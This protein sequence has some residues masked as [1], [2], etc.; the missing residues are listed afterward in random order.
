MSG[1]T[2]KKY[3]LPNMNFEATAIRFED[4]VVGLCYHGT[5]IWQEGDPRWDETIQ[6]DWQTIWKYGHPCAFADLPADM[7]LTCPKCGEKISAGDR[8]CRHCGIIFSK[9]LPP[10]GTDPAA[11]AVLAEEQAVRKR[12]S[13]ILD[14]ILLVVALLI[15]AGLGYYFFRP[16]SSEAPSHSVPPSTRHALPPAKSAPAD[17]PAA[18]AS[19]PQQTGSTSGRE[20]SVSPDNPPARQP[21]PPAGGFYSHINLENQAEA[22]AALQ[23]E[24]KQIENERRRLEEAQARAETPAAKE[25]LEKEAT[26][27]NARLTELRKIVDAYNE[28]Y[29]K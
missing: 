25:A 29:A 28:R 6:E 7:Q 19:V 18:A 8:E 20:G 17:E 5:T 21:H 27:Y 23:K 4:G 11:E 1:W 15:V 13:R 16:G 22:E 14:G 26:L 3:K 2:A 10:G 12:R 9:V 24:I